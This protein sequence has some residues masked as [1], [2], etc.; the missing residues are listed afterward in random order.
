MVAFVGS[1]TAF[2]QTV[3]HYMMVFTLR[4]HITNCD[5]ISQ[6]RDW[7]SDR[8]VPAAR[9]SV[10]INCPKQLLAETRAQAIGQNGVSHKRVRRQPNYIFTLSTVIASPSIFPLT[11]T[12]FP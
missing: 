3:V 9:S 5:H 4:E 1:G 10:S 7:F 8:V 12:F 2:D 11:V 6:L